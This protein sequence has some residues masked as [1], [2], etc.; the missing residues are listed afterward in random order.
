[1]KTISTSVLILVLSLLFTCCGIVGKKNREWEPVKQEKKYFIHIVIWPEETLEL[2]SSWHTG[3]KSNVTALA[4]ANPNINPNKIIPGDNIYIPA[5]L[6][7]AKKP[8]PREFAKNFYRKVE[9][10]EPVSKPASKPV[11]KQKKEKEFILFGP[12]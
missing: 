1:M 5:A 12:K 2:I 4:E 3:S 9:K 10:K 6:L 11:A 8:V 7:K